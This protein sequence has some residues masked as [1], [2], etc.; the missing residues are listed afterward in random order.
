MKFYYQQSGPYFTGES[1]LGQLLQVVERVGGELWLYCDNGETLSGEK[2][3]D[4]TVDILINFL[5]LVDDV[6][7]ADQGSWSEGP[8]VELV[9]GQDP[10]EFLK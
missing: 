5:I 9:N 3:H 1:T 10:R 8:G 2:W 7:S 6:T 4:L